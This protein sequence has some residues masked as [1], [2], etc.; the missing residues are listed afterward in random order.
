MTMKG[1]GTITLAMLLGFTAA[2]GDDSSG[3]GGNIVGK[4]TGSIQASPGVLAFADVSLGDTGEQTV[5]VSNAGSGI[6]RISNVQLIEDTNGDEGGVEF[7]KDGSVW[8]ERAELATDEFIDLRV[9]YSPLDQSPDSGKIVIASNDPEHGSFEIPI[10]TR[11]LAPN[12]YSNPEIVFQR[13]APVTDETRDKTFR[14]SEVQ[15][16]GQ[17]PLVISR[18]VITGSDDFKIT[19][20][21]SD[22]EN[23]DPATDKTDAPTTLAPNETFPI[24]VYFNPVDNNPSTADLI[25]FSNDP[26]EGQYT[27]RLQGNSGAPCIKLSREDEINFGEGGIGFANNKTITIENCSPTQDLSVSD[28]EISDDGGGVFEIKEGT[29]PEGL[30]AAPAVIPPDNSA[31]FVISYTPE[32]E[33]LSNGELTV[34]SNDPAKSTLKVP[35]IG[36]GTFNVCPQAKPDARLADS[37]V[38][39]QTIATIPLK[40]VLLDGTGSVDAN[41]SIAT[42]EWTII[43]RPP[44]SN[45]RLDPSNSD[46]KPSLFLDLAGVYIIELTVYDEQGLASCNDDDTKRVTVSA[47]P[48]EDI[49]IQLV[50][51]SP[52]DAV[53]TDTNGTDLDLHYLHPSAPSWNSRPLDIFWD[54]RTAD[55]GASGPQDDPSLDIDDTN[56]AG[57]EN[58]NH[59][60]PE[61]GLIYSVGVYYYADR[62]FGASYATLRVY[63][64]GT[65]RLE[66]RNQF[67]PTQGTFWKAVAISW[68]SGQ[69]SPIN[70]ITNGFP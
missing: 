40:T 61:S 52:G 64:Q 20:P 69:I 37:P 58:I 60:H 44:N 28:I 10:E 23:A 39:S 43:Q 7:R 11:D 15:N 46:P 16:T 38:S 70:Q 25:F 45:A 13:V 63:I 59:N 19:Y 9:I 2:C 48:D 62:G 65:Q 55:W 1:I 27:V 24:R 34:R 49:H 30:P 31:S 56:G 6:L 66:Y 36:K 47:V 18:V 35:I 5:R 53:Q 26:D 21:V 33:A 67:L 14:L 29:L 8:A 51:D 4:D 22:D 3:G 54:N 17:V 68:P 42:Y 32:S 41:G 57:P 50:W 12:I